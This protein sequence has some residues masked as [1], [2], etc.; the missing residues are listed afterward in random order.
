[1]TCDWGMLLSRH[2]VSGYKGVAPME[3]ELVEILKQVRY[4]IHTTFFR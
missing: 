1:M 2:Y 3:L 4:V